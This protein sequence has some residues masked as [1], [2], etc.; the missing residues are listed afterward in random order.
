[1]KLARQLE[2]AFIIIVIYYNDLKSLV[3]LNTLKVLIVLND[4]KNP[5][6]F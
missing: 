1:M 4:F 6:L 5:L 3:T 2:T